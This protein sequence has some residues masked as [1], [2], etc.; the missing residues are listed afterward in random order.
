MEP[1][2]RERRG[3]LTRF[4]PRTRERPGSGDDLQETDHR[5]RVDLRPNPYRFK[6]HSVVDGTIAYRFAALASSS[7]QRPTPRVAGEAR[8]MPLPNRPERKR[9]RK[10]KPLWEE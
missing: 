8:G 3:V 2:A 5:S 4:K 9:A 6:A 7:E 10:L 1:P